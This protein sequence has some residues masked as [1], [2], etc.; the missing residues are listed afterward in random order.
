V[1]TRQEPWLDKRGLASH[2]ACS[3]RSVET[4]LAEGLPHAVIFG[5]VKFQVSAAEPWLEERGYLV[6]RSGGATVNGQQWGGDADTSRP[7]TQGADPRAS[8]E[9]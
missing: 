2:L 9:A 3:V 7:R 6:R 8:E 5:R 4:A 1:L